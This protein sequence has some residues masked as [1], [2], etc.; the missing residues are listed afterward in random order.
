MFWELFERALHIA[1]AH[2]LQRAEAGS[3]SWVPDENRGIRR[4][5]GGLERGDC[6]I[7]Q[8]VLRNAA[9]LLARRGCARLKRR[10][11]TTHIVSP[12]SGT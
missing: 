12:C 6:R 5:T 7:G 11:L 8:M 3:V 1:P 9:T 2:S 4:A 10:M